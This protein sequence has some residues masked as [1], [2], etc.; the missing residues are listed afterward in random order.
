MKDRQLE[1]F[2]KSSPGE[3]TMM[4]AAFKSTFR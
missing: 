2:F 3:Y 1:K 4:R